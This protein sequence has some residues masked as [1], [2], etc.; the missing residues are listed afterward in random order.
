MHNIVKPNRMSVDRDPVRSLLT[1]LDS[2]EG[3]YNE[4]L[5]VTLD[6]VLYFYTW[7]RL[8]WTSGLSADCNG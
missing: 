4:R 5:T 6:Q 1:L 8:R 3:T 7:L 2:D